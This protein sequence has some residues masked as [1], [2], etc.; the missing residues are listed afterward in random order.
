VFAFICNENLALELKRRA[1][2][3]GA[4]DGTEG[5]VGKLMAAIDRV[6]SMPEGETL[7]RLVEPYVVRVTTSNPYSVATLMQL[8]NWFKPVGR[9]PNGP[10]LVLPL[11][12]FQTALLSSIF[13]RCFNELVDGARIRVPAAKTRYVNGRRQAAHDTVGDVIRANPSI[14]LDESTLYDMTDPSY[15]NQLEGHLINYFMA[16]NR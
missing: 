12:L 1:V 14:I 6:S 9:L 3:D 4:F 2:T 5:P 15:H 8:D 11:T 10:H 7:R 16:S 13:T